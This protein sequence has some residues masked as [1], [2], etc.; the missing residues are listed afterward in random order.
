MFAFATVCLF[1]ILVFFLF[2]FLHVLVFFLNVS[3]SVCVKFVLELV[4]LLLP[5]KGFTLR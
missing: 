2:L 1:L 4:S 3:S 5:V